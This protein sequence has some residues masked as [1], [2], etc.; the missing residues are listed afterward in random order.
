M[1]LTANAIYVRHLDSVVVITSYRLEGPGIE[2]R[3]G[4]GFP[5]PSRSALDTAHPPAQRATGLF[6]SGKAAGQWR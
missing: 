5:H 1:G 2:F 3:S 6:P 4:Q